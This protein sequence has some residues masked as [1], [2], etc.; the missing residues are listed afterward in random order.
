MKHN[1]ILKIGK[2][3]IRSEINALRKLQQSIGLSFVHAVDLICNTIGKGNVVFTGVGKSKLILEKTCGTFSSLGIPAYTLDCTA[4]AH[5][6]IGKIQQRDILIIASNSG[7]STEFDPIIKFAKG[8]KIKIIGITSN[9]KSL[10]YKN[11]TIKILHAKVKEAGYPILP[12]SSTTLLTALGDALAI[13]VAKKKKFALT[14]FGKFHPSGSIGKSFTKIEDLVI[15]KSKLPFIKKNQTFSKILIKIA[16][17]KL[18]CVLIKDNKKIRLITDG[19]CMRGQKKF[20]NLHMIQAK[21]I[22]TKNPTFAQSNI[23]VSEAL[24]ILNKKRI[25]ILLIKKRS[26]FIGLLSLHELLAFLEK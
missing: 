2:E 17:A 19:D 8:N 15:P 6:D 23:L 9:N 7:K 21:D 25:N 18:G 4:G 20:K 24:K 16:S 13:A 5:G 1:N 11:S 22:M 26:E 12:T 10:L 3:V 14:S